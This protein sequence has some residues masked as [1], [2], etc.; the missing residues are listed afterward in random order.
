MSKQETPQREYV[1]TFRDVLAARIVNFIMRTVATRHYREFLA[2]AIMYG[3]NSA[4]R[5]K[6]HDL[7]PPSDWWQRSPEK[8][9]DP[10]CFTDPDI[11]Q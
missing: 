2:G 7:K 1:S 5:D 8:A 3:M 10:P 6:A 9:F 4:A 11:D